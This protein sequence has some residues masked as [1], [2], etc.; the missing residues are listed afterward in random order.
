[1][2]YVA[3]EVG[4]CPI[5][6]KETDTGILMDKRLND[7]AFKDNEKVAT[8]HELCKEHRQMADNGMVALIGLDAEKSGEGDTLRPEDAHRTGNVM[9]MPAVMFSS[10]IN[11]EITGPVVYVEDDVIN[12]V[13]KMYLEQVGVD[14][15]HVR[16]RECMA[17]K[18][19]YTSSVRY[20]KETPNLS[21]EVT[22]YCP[23]CGKGG[24]VSGPMRSTN[25]CDNESTGESSADSEGP[26]E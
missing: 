5:C 17:C 2:S 11:T 15:D 25:E 1:M 20:A 8:H 7:D 16:D 19:K 26:A 9:H 18:H 10:M 6:N 14:L 22:E 13:K 12:M 24:I 4:V 3:M 23:E 21:G